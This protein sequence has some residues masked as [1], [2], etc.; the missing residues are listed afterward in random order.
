LAAPYELRRQMPTAR[1]AAGIGEACD[2]VYE[3]GQQLIVQRLELGT[4]EARMLARSGFAL[5]LAALVGLTGWLYLLS[6][7]VDGLARSQPRFVVEL[8]VGAFHVAL[9]FGLAAVSWNAASNRSGR[10]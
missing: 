7:L 1:R 10:P 3:A 9:A 8:G 5:G 2:R 6:G 4:Q